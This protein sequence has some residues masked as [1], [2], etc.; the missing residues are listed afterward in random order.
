MRDSTMQTILMI[1]PEYGRI[2]RVAL[3]ASVALWICG[4]FLSN[5]TAAQVLYEV[6]ESL[7]SVANRIYERFL[8]AAIGNDV[9][10]DVH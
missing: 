3:A 5:N 9:N 8:G 4:H 10:I 6:K 2:R 7:S 1:N